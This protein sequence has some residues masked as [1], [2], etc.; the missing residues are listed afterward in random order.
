M[1]AYQDY[2]KGKAKGAKW[3]PHTTSQEEYSSGTSHSMQQA[4]NQ[5]YLAV[6]QSC[7]RRNYDRAVKKTC[8]NCVEDGGSGPISQ[9]NAASYG[10]LITAFSLSTS[11]YKYDGDRYLVH[12]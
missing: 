10:N 6:A 8:A 11:L 5:Q 1:G 4:Y 3:A 9:S 2:L 7:N 12:V